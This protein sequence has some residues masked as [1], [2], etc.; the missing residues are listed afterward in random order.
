MK[1]LLLVAVLAVLGGLVGCSDAV[2]PYLT[3]IA[4]NPGDCVRCRGTNPTIYRSGNLQQRPNEGYKQSRNVEFVD[5]CRQHDQLGRPRTK[6]Q[7]RLLHHYGDL[8]WSRRR[9]SHWYDNAHRYSACPGLRYRHRHQRCHPGRSSLATT[10]IAKGTGHQYLA[11][12]IYSD[13][14]VRNITNTV[15]W[16]SSA[17]A[18]ATIASTGRATSVG[19]GTAT[20]T[21]TDPTTTLSGS[22]S[23]V[24]TAA[25]ISSVVVYPIG[26]SSCV[27]R[28]SLH[29]PPSP[30]RPWGCSSTLRDKT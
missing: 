6:L 23:L 10:S 19:A 3:T 30:S 1:R 29:I 11:Y 16:A 13:G 27:G 8:H 28:P 26:R 17:V 2:F 5:A 9:H 7:P 14:G 20:I 22:S 25:T 4:V 24:V 18:V 21:A 12:G 15:T